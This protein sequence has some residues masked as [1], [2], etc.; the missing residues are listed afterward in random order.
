EAAASGGFVSANA[1]PRFAGGTR[2]RARVGCEMYDSVGAGVGFLG[3]C[4]PVGETPARPCVGVSDRRSV[5]SLPPLP[6]L[7]RRSARTT[8]APLAKRSSRLLAVRQSRN[9]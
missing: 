2:G 5:R 9:S 4:V 1:K 8:S 6:L 7:M 3:S